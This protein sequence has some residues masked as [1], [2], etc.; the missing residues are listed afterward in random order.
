MEMDS[1]EV[2]TLRLRAAE[3]LPGDMHRG[4]ARL[5]TAAMTYLHV[6]TGEV[7]QV[8]GLRATV[9]RAVP[10]DSGMPSRL[11][12]IDGATRQNAGIGLD[13]EVTVQKLG[14]LPARAVVLTPMDG[15]GQPLGDEIL[16][17]LGKR[18]L[19]CALIAGDTVALP[20]F[21]GEPMLFTVTGTSPKGAV[22]VGPDSNIRLAQV[23][24]DGTRARSVTYE[25]VGGLDR[26]LARVRELVELPLKYPVLFRQLGVKPP[27]GVLLYGPPGTGKTLI[28]RAI[29]SDN[30]LHF[31][32]VD[33]PEIMRKYY[34]E[35][36]GRLREVFAEA[37]RHAPSVIFL[38]EMDALAPRREAVHGDVEK[39]VVGQLL[40][41]MDGLE[42]RGDV[43]VVG[44]TNIPEM[45][46]PALRRPGRFDREVQVPVPNR[47]GR[48]AI[49][50]IHTRGMALGADVNLDELA[51]T[52]H[53]FVGA[54]VAALCREAGMAALRRYLPE[55]KL[56]PQ[57][58]ADVG[59]IRVTMDDFR[60][61]LAEVEPSA[62]REL[63]LDRPREDWESVGGLH[64]VRARLNL[65]VE[66]PLQ[67]GDT[68]A[69]FGLQ[70]PRGILFT[71]PSGTG[72]T[73]IARA[74]GSRIAANFI[75]IEGPALFRKWMGET[76]KG[77]RDLFRKARQAAPCVLFID[78]LDALAPVRGAAG[79]TEGSERAVSQLLS[80]LDGLR[81]DSGVIVIGATNRPDRLEPALLRSGRFDYVLEFQLPDA[82]ERAEILAVHTRRLPL[83]GDVNLVH[84][85]EQTR[86]W[87]GAGL[88]AL[89]QRAALLAADQWL[90]STSQGPPPRVTA[91]HFSTAQ[92]EMEG[93]TKP[94]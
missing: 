11:V 32:H 20:R 59:E 84:L 85:A 3:A 9:A 65:L 77:L 47:T 68:L 25:D 56:D 61:G 7:V 27:R 23:E 62:T 92:A 24:V 58:G 10:A 48:R 1:G 22:I 71:G 38:D 66:R 4:V 15:R 87:T 88:R 51:E 72:K 5:S 70:L 40:A 86:G 79:L 80:E 14:A 8:T 82:A 33:G 12:L 50:H 94:K 28:A 52:T 43:I 19:D 44:A 78:E 31:L 89:A 21:S 90:D 35:S 37:R 2:K 29:A 91:V 81:E 46:D 54:D 74:L 6:S 93:G 42:D 17:S 36:E 67:F 57:K 18:L 75:G 16:P 13:E 63:V 26:E 41:L 73:L 76:E 30:R 34:G 45:L 64:Q 69:R 49:F 39:R 53:G 60:A 55:I 83:A